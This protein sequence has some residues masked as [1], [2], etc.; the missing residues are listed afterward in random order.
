MGCSGDDGLDLTELDPIATQLD[1][2]VRPPQ[3]LDASV[4]VGSGRDRPSYRVARRRVA[5]RMPDEP[6]CGEVRAV[7]YPRATPSPPM[8]SSPATPTGTG[9]LYGSRMKHSVLAI[10]LPTVMESADVTRSMVDQDRRLRG[11]VHVPE[12]DRMGKERRRPDP[13]AAAPR[14]KGP[15][16][17]ERCGPPAS[18]SRRQVIGVACITVTPCSISER[19]NAAPSLASPAGD[20][21]ASSGKQRQVEFETGDVE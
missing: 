18:S 1:L 9:L 19:R 20:D 16:S 17:D 7:R 14:R 12:L 11:A 4:R 5:K 13:A 15:S 2:V 6:L 3:D 21:H 8:K 10:G